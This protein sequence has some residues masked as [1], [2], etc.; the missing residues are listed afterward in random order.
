M[1]DMETPAPAPPPTTLAERYAAEQ[2][3]A[4]AQMAYWNGR[5]DLLRELLDEGWTR[6]EPAITGA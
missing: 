6:P 1:S 5:L 4:E 2:R 3:A